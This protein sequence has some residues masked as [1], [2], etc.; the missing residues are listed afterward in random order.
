MNNN[1]ETIDYNSNESIGK[2]SLKVLTKT[3]LLALKYL[4]THCI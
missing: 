4:L 2:D 1:Y 3:R